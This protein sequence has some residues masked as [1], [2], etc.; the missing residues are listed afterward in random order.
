MH[1]SASAMFGRSGKCPGATCDAR[2]EGSACAAQ[3]REIYFSAVEE[4]TLIS[5][6]Q[7]HF[8]RHSTASASCGEALMWMLG[9]RRILGGTLRPPRK[10]WSQFCHRTY[11]SSLLVISSARPPANHCVW[12]KGNLFQWITRPP[13]LVKELD[14]EGRASR[15]F[16]V[17]WAAEH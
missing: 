13:Y 10:N 12:E 6:H 3:C 4:Q 14:C 15:C 5:S 7:S 16:F 1:L 9:F 17:G 8:R 2:S 11:C